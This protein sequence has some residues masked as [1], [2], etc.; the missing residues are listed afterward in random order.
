MQ[1]QRIDFEDTYDGLG[2]Q[3]GDEDD[4]L[5]D[6]TFGGA[7]LA[8]QAAPKPVGKDYDFFG[9]TAKVSTAID[10]EQMRYSRQQKPPQPYHAQPSPPKRSNPPFKTGYE[11]Y[12]DPEYMSGLQVNAS[13]WGPSA[14]AQGSQARDNQYPPSR[15]AQNSQQPSISAGQQ[16]LSLEEV[17]AQ[18]A[19]ESKAQAQ[20]KKA[21]PAPPSQPQAQRPQAHQPPLD[22]RIGPQPPQYGH[23]RQPSSQQ[24]SSRPAPSRNYQ[25]PPTTSQAELPGASI[26][27]VRPLGSQVI[28]QPPLSSQ[29]GA[30]GHD[31]PPRQI[32][33]NPNR[34]SA[35]M[36]ERALDLSQ[37]VQLHGQL[38]SS[39]PNGMPIITDPQQ[40]M[41]LSEEQRNAYLAEDAKRAKR[42]HKIFLLSRD[43][44]LMTPQ[45]KNFI[46]RIQLSQLMTAT[47]NVNTNSQET[48]L[49]EDFYYQ[50]HSH[51][52]GGRRQNP[53]QPLSNFA[54]TYL[55]QTGNRHGQN[56]KHNRGE[57]HMQRMEMQVQRAVESAKAR[58]KN[59]QLVIQGSLGKISFS[60]SKTPKPL[61]NLKRN[62][63]S[64]VRRPSSATGKTTNKKAVP[65][66]P[67]ARDRKTILRIIED[68]YL[69]LM[70]IEDHERH[71]PHTAVDDSDPKILE[72]VVDWREIM[73]GMVKR[74]WADSKIMEPI[75]PDANILHP[76]IAF[77]SYP[78]GKKAIP[79]I[80]RHVS[81]EQRLT[82]MTIIMVHL[83][84]LDVI[85]LD[86]PNESRSPSL[87]RDEV[88]L[89]SQTVM[90]SL[91][92][93][94]ND[95]ELTIVIGVLSLILARVD[96]AAISR[97]KVGLSIL[98]MLLSRAEIIKQS[99][100]SAEAEWQQWADL[101]NRLFDALEPA[102]GGIFPVSVNEGQDMYIW[103]F[104][105]SL[106]VGASPEL[107]QRLVLAVK[108]RVM[109]T[110]EQSKTL[111]AD[112]ASQRLGNVNLFMRAIGLDVDWL[113]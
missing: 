107:Q 60:N 70:K 9:Q 57:N 94:I 55:F 75:Q 25:R 108:D 91:F 35:Q 37:P 58:P 80:F 27:S 52:R 64:D 86:Q 28:Q 3:L 81:P 30:H 32:L 6:A 66:A 98:T 13:I 96:I 106:G 62:G 85:I 111:P 78:K 41:H 23:Q 46:T 99:D 20:T 84:V 65:H 101:Y 12:K 2:D 21:P 48:V 87:Q 76:F 49:V 59:Q 18:L 105:A 74:L 90:P 103:Q 33:Q 88:E 63:G 5:N 93:L 19:A 68:V 43:N 97:T 53:Q 1:A 83:N 45:D 31:M 44:G 104:L 82:I 4:A 36:E 110:V 77:L 16:M 51:I 72:Q 89:F 40:L 17:E 42:N 95:A 39:V 34:R 15:P 73:D 38:P 112:M 109:E 102:L 67:N 10:E 100:S 11:A 47:G 50:V 71:A 8:P 79:R 22:I 26:P 61:L 56:R 29:S 14:A 92:A 113:G 54:Q 7:S 24:F 69:D